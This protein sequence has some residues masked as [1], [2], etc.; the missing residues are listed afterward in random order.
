MPELHDGRTTQIVVTDEAYPGGHWLGAAIPGGVVLDTSNP[1]EVTGTVAVS[2]VSGTVTV[3]GIATVSGTVAVSSIAGAVT[4]D[5]G[6]VP[7]AA[8]IGKGAPNIA[9]GQVTASGTAATLVAARA[10][11]RGVTMKNLDTVIT[12]YV[13]VATVT[14]ANGMPLRAGESMSI[15]ST[16]L[17][18]V[19]AASGSPVVA[20]LETY[21]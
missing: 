15:D 12:V 9:N 4:L 17:V 2:G 13:G 16:A 5:S 21:D 8:S 3:S 1:I 14:T 19:I 11:R 20:Y 10:T 6:S 18:Q 7:T